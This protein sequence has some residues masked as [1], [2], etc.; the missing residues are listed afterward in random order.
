MASG[1][2]ERTLRQRDA[3][4]SLIVPVH[5]TAGLQILLCLSFALLL[6]GLGAVAWPQQFVPVPL[7]CLLEI[8]DLVASSRGDDVAVLNYIDVRH[9]VR[10]GIPALWCVLVRLGQL[11]PKT[12][13]VRWCVARSCLLSPGVFSVSGCHVG[14]AAHLFTQLFHLHSRACRRGSPA[15]HPLLTVNGCDAAAMRA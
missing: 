7:E 13:W 4:T 5:W 11:V 2:A 9:A 3:N 12:V 15:A 10:L 8:V 14:A 1:G 6:F